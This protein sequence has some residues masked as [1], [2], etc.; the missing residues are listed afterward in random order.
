[1][2]NNL[3]CYPLMRKGRNVD[4]IIAFDSSADIQVANW[5]AYVEGY[6]KQ[7]KIKGW[8]VSIGWPK[9][10]ESEKKVQQELEE[11]H[12]KSTAEAKEK[13][14]EA[15][16]KD[17]TTKGG[18]PVQGVTTALGPCTVWVGSMEA[19]E[20]EDEPPPGMAVEE[21]WESLMRPDSGMPF[22]SPRTSW[23][24]LSIV[25][26]SHCGPS[27]CGGRPLACWPRE[28]EHS[29]DQV[30]SSHI[31]LLSRT[32]TSRTSTQIPPRICQ[33]GTLRFVHIQFLPWLYSLSP[34]TAV[35]LSSRIRLNLRWS[36]HLTAWAC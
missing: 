31:S 19:R 20:S 32:P 13:L 24:S 10:D 29:H 15:Q 27:Q 14:E 25:A 1:M 6:A 22:F 33:H 34:V 17:D 23:Q 2:S 16:E 3:A 35:L 5:I 36:P 12:A 8:P 11:A 30:S 9:A 26:L 28:A 21:E 7:R 4:I 18:E